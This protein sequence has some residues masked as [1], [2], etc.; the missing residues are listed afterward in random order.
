M[1]TPFSKYDI[2]KENSSK[3]YTLKCNNNFFKIMIKEDLN[4]NIID[5]CI[6]DY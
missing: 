2:T 3:H 5:N 4:N 6:I 1:F